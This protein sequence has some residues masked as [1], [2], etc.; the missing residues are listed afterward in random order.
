MVALDFEVRIGEPVGQRLR[1]EVLSS[2]AGECEAEATFPYDTLALE[3]RLQALQL[4]LL[5]GSSRRRRMVGEHERT[6]QEFGRE[7]FESVFTGDVGSL[8]ERS[9]EQ[10][11]LQ[12]S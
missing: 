10:A 4:A 6:V 1:V 9:R 2:P 5:A 12:G 8:L 3:N 7:L 11:S